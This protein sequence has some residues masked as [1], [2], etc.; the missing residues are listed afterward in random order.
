MDVTALL[1]A[2]PV[3]DGHND[4]MW[5]AREQAGYDFSRLDVGAGSVARDLQEQRGPSLARIEDLDGPA[6]T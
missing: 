3:I 1:A 5:E 4:L 6:A 2:H